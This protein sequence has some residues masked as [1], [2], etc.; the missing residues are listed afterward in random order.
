MSRIFGLRRV[1]EDASRADASASA[2]CVFDSE[3]FNVRRCYQKH[4]VKERTR[5]A[6]E[7]EIA[8]R[9][10]QNRWRM[11]KKYNERRNIES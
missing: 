10:E 1:T 4:P 8:K 3:A 6:T 9:M 7:N 5:K 11:A 2:P